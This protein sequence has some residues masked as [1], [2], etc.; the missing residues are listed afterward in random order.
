MFSRLLHVV[1]PLSISDLPLGSLSSIGSSDGKMK[2]GVETVKR[3]CWFDATRVFV[4]IGDEMPHPPAANPQHLNWRTEVAAL[5]TQGICVYAVQALNRRHA[6]PF[7]RELGHTSGGFHL[8]LE[9]FATFSPARCG[10]CLALGC[11]FLFRGG[12]ALDRGSEWKWHLFILSVFF[13]FMAV[14]I[15]FVLSLID[16]C[17][18]NHIECS[19]DGDHHHC[20]KPGQLL[21]V[22]A[23]ECW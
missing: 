12:E 19:I 5:T 8:R 17:I 15:D 11:R 23:G 1:F 14:P 6:T 7:Y 2:R 20:Q 18:S 9:Q 21:K 4:L 10:R 13:K 22:V 3:Q 16:T